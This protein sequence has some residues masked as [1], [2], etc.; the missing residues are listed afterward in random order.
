MLHLKTGFQLALWGV[1]IMVDMK[2]ILL[3]ICD[4][5]NSSKKTKSSEENVIIFAIR[6]AAAM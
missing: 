4:R 1:G 6:E 3:K 5:K 2:K